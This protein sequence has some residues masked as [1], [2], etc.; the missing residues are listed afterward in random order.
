MVFLWGFLE[1][2]RKV[3]NAGEHEG[4]LARN[5]LYNHVIERC[6]TV[7]KERFEMDAIL[8]CILEYFREKSDN[9]RILK[10]VEKKAIMSSS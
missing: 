2:C 3:S 5:D 4:F 6:A 7:S 10:D 8:R 9:Q 1:Q